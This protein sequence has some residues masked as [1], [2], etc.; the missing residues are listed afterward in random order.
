MDQQ[1]PQPPLAEALASSPTTAPT[2]NVPDT[3]SV[4]IAALLSRDPLEEAAAEKPND[5]ARRFN[6]YEDIYVTRFAGELTVIRV[7]F[8]HKTGST[9]GVYTSRPASSDEQW[10]AEALRE[11]GAM[12]RPRSTIRIHTTETDLVDAVR[13]LRP[14]GAQ[15]SAEWMTDLNRELARKGQFIVLARPE[16]ETPMWRKVMQMIR[17]GTMPVPG[18]LVTYMVHTAAFTDYDNVYCGIVT[19]GLG[20]IQVYHTVQPGDDLVSA[21]LDM[22]QWLLEN[23]PGGGRIQVHHA[24]DGARRIWDQAGLL[25]EQGGTDQLGQSGVRLRRL[26]REAYYKKTHIDLGRQP[27]PVFA[28]FAK[29]AAGHAFAGSAI[30]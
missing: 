4:D 21:E 25:A 20:V 12:S 13:A 27:I 17:E 1:L 3:S 18:P 8:D 10:M 6:Q 16:R 14:G 22:V 2:S 19:A 26:A 11:A 28:T 30:L 7:F 29:A 9:T 24:T 5:K 15:K 23:S